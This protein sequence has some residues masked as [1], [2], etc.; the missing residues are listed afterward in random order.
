MGIVGKKIPLTECFHSFLTFL[1]Y[2]KNLIVH[3]TMKSKNIVMA[4][5]RSIWEIRRSGENCLEAKCIEIATAP[6]LTLP[7]R[8]IGAQI[9]RLSYFNLMSS[10]ISFSL[11]PFQCLCQILRHPDDDDFPLLKKDFHC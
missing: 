6:V 10:L 7:L 2:L 3:S 1:E 9:F 5:T 4:I 8:N 11:G